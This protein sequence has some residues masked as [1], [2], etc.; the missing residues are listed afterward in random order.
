MN[1]LYKIFMLILFLAIKNYGFAQ[2]PTISSF[3]PTSGSIG[4]LVTIKGT[5]LNNIDTIKIGGVSA[6]KISAKTDTL[7]AMVMPGAITGNIY[8]T[9][10]TGNVSSTI[11]FNK[12]A[13]IA[14]TMQQGNKLVGTGAVGNA[15]QGAVAISGDGNTALVGGSGDNGGIGAVWVYVRNG[16]IWTQQGSKLVGTGAIG[17]AYQGGKVSLSADGNMALISGSGDNGGIGAAWVFTRNGN[18]WS[19]Q[20]NKLVGTGA[21]GSSRQ[22]TSV[23]LSADGS[24]AIIGGW[25][26]NNNMGAAWVFARSG[27][28]WSQIGNKLVGT[29]VNGTYIA[30]GTSV[31]L[32]ADGN[33]AIIGGNADNFFVGAAWVFTRIGNTWIQQGSKLVGTGFNNSGGRV[34]Q[35]RSVS[36]SADGNTALIGANYDNN[37]A[38]AAWVFTRSGS[39]WS[40]QGSKLVGTNGSA[41]SQQGCS[42]SLSADGNTAII[43]GEN[44]NNLTGA[45]WMFSRTGNTWSQ[46]GNKIIGNATVGYSRFGNSVAISS[47]GNTA[48]AGGWAD[49]N[50]AGAA[51]VFTRPFTANLTNILLST[52]S[53]NP[54]FNKDTLSYS[55]TVVNAISSISITAFK[56]DTDANIQV[57]INNG[58]YIPVNS[59]SSSNPLNLNGGINIISIKVTAADGV[60]IKIYTITI[61]RLPSIPIINS[62]S[63]TSGSIG[64]LVT[65][66]G[67]SL[68]NIDTLKIGGVSALKISSSYDSL[69]AMVMPGASTGNIYVANIYGSA[70]STANFTKTS[71]I[72]PTTQQGNKLVGTGA[73]GQSYQ[74]VSVSLS[75]DGNTAI[76]GG[77][78]DNNS[79]GAAWIYTRNGTNWN[80]QGVKLV[81]TGAIGSYS[82]QGIAVKISADGNTA[83][84]G[85]YTDNSNKGAVWIYTRIG[86]TWTQQGPKLVGTGAVG[87]AQQGASVDLSADGNVAIVGGYSDNNLKGAFWIFTRNGN[88]W[89]QLGNKMVGTGGTDTCQQGGSVSISADA[90]TCLIGGFADNRNIGATWVFTRSGNNWIQQGGKL[91]GTGL[92]GQCRQ[93]YS[94]SL[95]ADGNTALVGALTDSSSFGASLIFTRTGNTWTQQG[96]KLVG[97]G[98]T[99]TAFQGISVSLSTDGN[100]A[101]IG[102]RGDN[103]GI[104][105]VW[106]FTRSGNSWT[107]FGNK[108][109]GTGAIGNANQGSVALSADGKT[110]IVGGA[111]DNTNIGA[112]WIFRSAASSNADLSNLVISN[113]TISPSFNKDSINYTASVNNASVTITPSKMD[114]NASIEIRING[115]VFNSITS[116]SASSPIVLNVGNNIIEIK[117]TAQD[118]ITTKTYTILVNNP[119]PVK[120]LDFKATQKDENAIL[121]NWSTASETNNSHFEIERLYTDWEMIGTLKGK[122]TSN[123]INNYQFIDNTFS[124]SSQSIYYR[125]KQKDYDGKYEYSKIAVVHF[126]KTDD[127]IMIFPNPSNQ[128]VNISSSQS[129]QNIEVYDVTGK[130]VLSPRNDNHQ[131]HIELN[132]SAFGNGIYFIQ[133][134][135]NDIKSTHK[136]IIE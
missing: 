50:S 80:Q 127:D 3:S 82:S 32:S 89:S 100:T 27:N 68:S 13:S 38:G 11:S 135:S 119:L 124:T 59:G 28:T 79:M 62:F 35:G 23:S 132:L 91:L 34:D 98:N 4:T 69:V 46:I 128:I 93:G 53:I 81:G 101:I 37:Q 108:L 70:T 30:Q 67:S 7:V 61:T 113:A 43:G 33:T 73:S 72:P 71:S 22:G 76:V 54:A 52:G 15:E 112:A 66:L 133:V 51:W 107:Q 25:A 21:I 110:V 12:T 20:G 78:G 106:V 120:W 130:L 65:I 88:T 10:A 56:Q 16:S 42:V 94:V 96:N 121:L 17:T 122:G 116:G 8:L 2:A 134:T 95:S 41:N 87:N 126:N 111:R 5:N 114:S 39:V 83:I 117:V 47:D 57:N 40:Q 74:G 85:G 64:T 75:S 18:T 125:I 31:S 45:V 115:G 29:G 86:N 6:I 26:D 60:I 118:A 136:L 77:Y 19:Q 36:L 105:A 109:I 9:N 129:I 90:N 97:T 1:H 123:I 102:G 55:L 48:F 14:P 104:G 49:D 58:S 131:K 99:G 44:D 84:V 92:I 24:T 103:G 63:P